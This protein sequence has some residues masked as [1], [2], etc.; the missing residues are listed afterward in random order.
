MIDHSDDHRGKKYIY[1]N[2]ESRSKE[3]SFESSDYTAEEGF[4]NQ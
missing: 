1:K 2:L 3:V 4:S